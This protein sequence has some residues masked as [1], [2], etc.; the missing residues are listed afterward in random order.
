MPE[1]RQRLDSVRMAVGRFPLLFLLWW[2]ISEGDTRGLWF[3]TVAAALVAWF[4]AR[5][6]VDS[7]HR[8]RW[9][10]LPGFAAFFLVES[11]AAGVDVAARLLRP[12]LPI[13]PGKITL[14]T[15]LPGGAPHW[16]LA[17]TLSLLPGTLSV[18]LRGDALVLHGLDLRMDL[19]ASVRKVE[20]RIARLFGCPLEAPS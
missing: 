18:S 19:E 9:R 20:T 17:N 8:I 15:R 10:A 1:T 7:E 3:G 2:I 13:Q 6:F 14:A 16:L 12:S 11:V 4:S 5:F